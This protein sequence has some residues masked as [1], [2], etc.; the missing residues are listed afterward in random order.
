M[1]TQRPQKL[2]NTLLSLLILAC[3][4][5]AQAQG[6]PG[7]LR[8]AL[9]DQFD[10]TAAVV[11]P[12]VLGSNRRADTPTQR[13]LFWNEIAINVSGI[14]HTRPVLGETRVFGEQLGPTRASRAIAIVHI[15]MFDAVNA[16]VG[17]FQSYSTDLPAG[18]ETTHSVDAAI[19]Q[20]ARDTL[21]ALYPSQAVS[22]DTVFAQ[23]RQ[24]IKADAQVTQAG[25]AIGQA[26]AKA[27]LNLRLNDGSQVPEPPIGNPNNSP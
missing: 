24:R 15:A 5:S 10:A 26:A 16:I 9:G 7:G 11:A 19:A 22:I 1:L 2:A 27:I 20:A 3:A 8:G 17:G 25:S 14:D 6:F 12:P 21:V 4:G 13:L 23:D 18:S